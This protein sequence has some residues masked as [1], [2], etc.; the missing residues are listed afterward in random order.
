ML[1]ILSKFH[2]KDIIK[3]TYKELF[4]ALVLKVTTPRSKFKG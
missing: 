2:I 3:E 4:L 1:V